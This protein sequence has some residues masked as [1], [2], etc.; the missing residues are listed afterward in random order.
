MDGAAGFSEV[1]HELGQK[2]ATGSLPG[3]IQ[4]TDNAADPRKV[5]FDL[6]NTDW[7]SVCRRDLLTS[8]AANEFL[9]L[10]S[11]STLWVM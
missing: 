7:N 1:A 5:T 10:S 11:S 6:W 2:V 8:Y 9:Q 3:G 4:G